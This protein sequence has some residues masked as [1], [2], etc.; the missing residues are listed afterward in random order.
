MTFANDSRVVA[1]QAF[2]DEVIAPNAEHWETLGRVPYDC[3]EQAAKAGLCG[4][5]VP[6]AL[7][8]SGLGVGAM[9]AVMESMASACMC[10]AFSFAVHNNLA[11]YVARYGSPSQIDRYLPDL[12]A[13]RKIGAF[14]LT[15]PSVGSDAQSI[16]TFAERTASGWI[17]NGEKAWVSNGVFADLI[18]VYV[19]TEHGSGAEGIAAF[20]IDA[21]APGVIREDAYKLMRG[22]A[23]GTAGFRFDQCAVIDDALVLAPG[24]AFKAAIA[25]I[26]IARI[27]VAAM[28]CGTLHASLA[29][30]IDYAD[31]RRAFGRSTL[32]FQGVQF[33]LADAA[34]N[35]EA[36]KL[37]TAS[38]IEQHD[39]GVDA[40][41]SAAHAKKFA[42]RAAFEGIGDCM[43]AMGAAGYSAEYSLGRHLA[44]AKM[45]QFLDGTSEIQNVVIGR[46]LKSIYGR[47]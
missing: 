16:K 11:G 17:I 4:L 8:G 1:A 42:T 19:Q 38:A 6:E 44:A 33:M 32:E 45:A 31:K 27:C 2:A 24:A 40:T 5:L 15:E 9:A 21:N 23:L 28:C 30:A 46:G 18:S 13:G 35:L 20:L 10:S 12:I 7:G 14:L 26:N 39:A 43:Q 22:H 25:G 36:A 41:I 3:F 37:L 34:T 29:Q 47:S